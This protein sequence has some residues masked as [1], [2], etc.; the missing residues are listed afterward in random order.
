MATNP[1]KGSPTMSDR[2]FAYANRV[3]KKKL[4]FNEPIPFS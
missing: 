4:V 3:G 2:L 1:S